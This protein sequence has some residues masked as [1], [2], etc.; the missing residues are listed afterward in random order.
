MSCQR[1][2]CEEE[3]QYKINNIRKTYYYVYI[4]L[5]IFHIPYTKLINIHI[6][7]NYYIYFVVYMINLYITYI[8]GLDVFFLRTKPDILV[9][10]MKLV[11]LMLLWLYMSI[12]DSTNSTFLPDK[13]FKNNFKI[14]ILE[15]LINNSFY[16]HN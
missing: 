3:E 2:I 16:L 8:V 10:Q 13:Y 4:T 5:H 11:L 9:L 12:I 14:L 1:C 7:H 15:V 6:G